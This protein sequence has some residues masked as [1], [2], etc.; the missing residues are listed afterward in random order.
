MEK[1]TNKNLSLHCKLKSWLL[2]YDEISVRLLCGPNPADCDGIELRSAFDDKK[3]QLRMG[4]LSP[5][6][7]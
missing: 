2:A 5:A 4:K 7:G 1:Q 6:N 3:L